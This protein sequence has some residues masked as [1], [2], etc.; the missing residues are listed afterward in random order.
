MTY[1]KVFSSEGRGIDVLSGSER[2]ELEYII[3]NL[4]YDLLFK[5]VRSAVKTE[6]K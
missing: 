5:W 4:N 3:K 2:D 1:G 6:M